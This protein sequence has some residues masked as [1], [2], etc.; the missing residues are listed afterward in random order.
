[1][2]I[3]K[4]RIYTLFGLI[5]AFFVLSGCSPTK[6]VFY[7]P[8]ENKTAKYQ[9]IEIPDFNKTDKEWVPYDSGLQIPDMVAEKLREDGQ[10]NEIRRSDSNITSEGKVLLVEGVV[11]GYNP[12]CKLCE[13][14]IRVNDKGKSSVTVRVKLI[15]KT[16]GDIITD[17]SIE[18]RAKKPGYGDS[19][20]IRIRDEIVKLIEEANN[21]EKS[22]L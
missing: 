14:Y 18:G 16:T 12:G 11:T 8:L 19:R 17:A 15:D 10:F 3:N 9:V 13:W 7:K 2:A 5:L 1:M 22:H 4:V 6:T 20:Y 21:G